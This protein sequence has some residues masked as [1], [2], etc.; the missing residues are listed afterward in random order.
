MSE[1]I[2]LKQEPIIAY[3]TDII[4][5]LKPVTTKKR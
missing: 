3:P 5:Y 4:K 2:T 1:I